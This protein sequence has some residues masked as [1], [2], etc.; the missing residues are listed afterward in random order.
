MSNLTLTST[1]SS[2][3]QM[4]HAVS[5][6][7]RE[8]FVP[9]VAAPAVE[10]P[11]A[12][13]EPETPAVP[14]TAETTESKPKDKPKSRAQRAIDKLT[15][16]NHRLEEELEQARK[17]PKPAEEAKTAPAT[18]GPPKL[19]D[20][21]NAGKTA[22]DWADA[23]DDWK[24]GEETK[25]AESARQKE[26]FDTYNKSISEARVRYEDWDE[27]V[28]ATDAVIP[29]SASIAVIEA[30]NGPDVAY[31]LAKHPEVCESLMDMTPAAVIMQIGRISDSL[32]PATKRSPSEVKPKAKA[33]APISTVGNSPTNSSVPLDQLSPR[34]YIRVRN[35]QERRRR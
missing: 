27:V 14:E 5:D 35:E 16:R 29:Q 19:Q 4:E 26:T 2:Q 15:A 25:Q 8:P 24:A 30:G 12:E 9:P 32:N 33:P 13:V 7:W 34:D 3:E 17:A 23:R 1:T 22:E 31:Y 11:E 28:E 20:Y 21:L 10:T 6:N 18:A